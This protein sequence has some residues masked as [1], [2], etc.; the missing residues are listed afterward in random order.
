MSDTFC[1]QDYLC[2]A[3]QFKYI[4]GPH[5][6]QTQSLASKIGIKPKRIGPG[7]EIDTKTSSWR[8]V[9]DQDWVVRDAYGNVMS[10]KPHDV[11]VSMY[12]GVDIKNN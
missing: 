6:P 7:W 2:T 3:D 4:D 8:S 10:V 1:P 5:G 11:F 12:R 9:G